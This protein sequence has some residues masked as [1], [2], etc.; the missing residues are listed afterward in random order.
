MRLYAF[1]A[2]SLSEGFYA[3][4]GLAAVMTDSPPRALFIRTFLALAIAGR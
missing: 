3:G 2:S 1:V 4:S